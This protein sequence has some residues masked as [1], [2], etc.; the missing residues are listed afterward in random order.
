MRISHLR[1]PHPGFLT[2]SLFCLIGVLILVPGK[3]AS[4]LTGAD[5]AL[6]DDSIAPSGYRGAWQDGVTALKYMLTYLGYSY[7]VITYNDLN[8]SA[9]NFSTLYKTIL[10]PGGY[11]QWYNYWINKFGKTRIRNFV[12]Q[13]GNYVGICAGAYFASDK[14]VWEGV[15]YDDN[16][17]YN[18]YGELTGYD[19]DLFAGTGTGPMNG[20]A[21]W[22]TVG[23]E[24]TTLNFNNSGT[25]S[26]SEDILYYGGPYFTPD[27]GAVVRTVATYSY[28]G[29][30]AIVS[31]P[32]GSGKVLLIGPHPEI[33]ED[34]ARD[35]VTISRED[36]L[37]DNG[38]DW[39]MMWYLLRAFAN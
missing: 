5:V 32:Y 15:T 25:I 8:S 12:Y 26:F 2:T 9:Q 7:E 3:N 37:D 11:A 4:A 39:T 10:F 24:M 22:D 20:I 27:S 35:G 29:A 18:A 16:V 14:I 28:N 13:G 6:Y 34:S 1:K 38:S 21:D 36:S 33:E 31:S 30:S 19:L 23:Y 17:D